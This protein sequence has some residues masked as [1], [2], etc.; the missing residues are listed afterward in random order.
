MPSPTNELT[1]SL[2]VSDRQQAAAFY[3]DTFGFDLVGDPPE[4]GLPEPLQYRLAEGTVLALIPSG[5]LDWVLGD[6]QLAPTGTSETLLGLTLDNE[7]SVDD[8][9]ERVRRAG[10]E[11]IAAPEGQEWGYA[12]IC[13]DL[14]GH[15]WQVIADG[16]RRD[17]PDSTPGP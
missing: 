4:D 10:G 12:A 2:P 3:R 7:Q 17:G 11:V 5:G 15:A 1:V 16:Q 9:V 8:L 14:D 6:R 13:A